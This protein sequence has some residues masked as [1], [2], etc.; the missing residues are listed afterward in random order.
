M[1]NSFDGT[2]RKPLKRRKKTAGSSL[3]TISRPSVPYLHH[4]LSP[5]RCLL[6]PRHARNTSRSKRH[7]TT[8]S[9]LH[10]Q[11][12]HHAGT[13]HHPH[14]QPHRSSTHLILPTPPETPQTRTTHSTS[15]QQ[16]PRVRPIYSSTEG[17]RWIGELTPSS[18]QPTRKVC[19]AAHWTH[20][21][22]PGGG[23]ITLT[24]EEHC[25]LKKDHT[26]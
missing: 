18:P 7:R 26:R 24:Q 9:Q 14:H 3:S 5:H 13:H 22:V 23:K 20:T 21:Y 19:T 10:L 15:Q 12:A 25:Q 8:M 4:P 1:N 11:S 6:H 17:H 2:C 16:Q